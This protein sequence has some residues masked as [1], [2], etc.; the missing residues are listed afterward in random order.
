[1]LDMDT[2]TFP[3]ESV[4]QKLSNMRE[5]LSST[6]K[7]S[8][9]EERFFWSSFSGCVFLLYLIWRKESLLMVWV[10]MVGY[11]RST[12]FYSRY[13]SRLFMFSFAK[14]SLVS[15]D[16]TWIIA[17]LCIY[18]ILALKIAVVRVSDIEIMEFGDSLINGCVCYDNTI[19]MNI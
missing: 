10:S 2:K 19:R 11:S 16:L 12:Q 17:I 3:W 9:L 13:C 5:Y 8:V 15:V 1:M 14:Y 6:S 7:H 18:M 4:S